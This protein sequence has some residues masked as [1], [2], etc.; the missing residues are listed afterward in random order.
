MRKLTSKPK[1]LDYSKWEHLINGSRFLYQ[2]ETRL[3]PNE[4][5]KVIAGVYKTSM[6]PLAR[7]MQISILRN[8]MYTRKILFNMQ[9]TA[10]PFFLFCPGI[11]ECRVHRLWLCPQSQKIWNFI[12][13]V[14]EETIDSPIFLKEAIL[15]KYKE[16]AATHRNLTILNTKWYIDQAKREEKAPNLVHVTAAL[17]NV[18]GVQFEFLQRLDAS[19]KAKLQSH[20]FSYYF[21]LSKLDELRH[22][23]NSYRLNS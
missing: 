7:D 4:A 14:L 8:N 5:G 22:N 15:G 9:V 10:D 18:L 23:K 20:I 17:T 16:S 6:V 3:L 13:R 12:N 19:A 21:F 2:L 11:E 1:E